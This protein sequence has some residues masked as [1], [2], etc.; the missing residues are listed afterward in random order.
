MMMADYAASVRLKIRFHKERE[1]RER[2]REERERERERK[3][4]KIHSPFH[5]TNID[6]QFFFLG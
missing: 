1:R 4:K 6:N 2:E 5:S 3:E